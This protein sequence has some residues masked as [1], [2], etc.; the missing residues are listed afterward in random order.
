MQD[1]A[2]STGNK[3]DENLQSS[4]LSESVDTN[5]VMQDMAP[6]TGTKNNENLPSWLTQMI[7][8]LRQVSDSLVWQDLVSSFV[9][10]ENF[11]PLLGVSSC[12]MSMGT[13]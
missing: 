11:G 13:D 5:V 7:V 6:S 2:A 10:F 4:P 3:N 1:M 9:E 8:Y 12:W